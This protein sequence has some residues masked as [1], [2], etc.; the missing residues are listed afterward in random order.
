MCS[1][2]ERN[3]RRRPTQ[4]FACRRPISRIQS[5]STQPSST[6]GVTSLGRPG[7]RK[8]APDRRAASPRQIFRLISRCR[9]QD[10]SS[11]AGAPGPPVRTGS[12]PGFSGSSR[13]RFP[14]AVAEGRDGRPGTRRRRR[15]IWTARECPEPDLPF[16]TPVRS[17]P[18]FEVGGRHLDCGRRKF[19]RKTDVRSPDYPGAVAPDRA[20]SAHHQGGI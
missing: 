14:L 9:S 17:M 20:P 16:P 5:T 1:L 18:F 11:D 2:S 3:R 15:R 10:V 19:R 7:R 4:K 6:G 12:R 8:R 13:R